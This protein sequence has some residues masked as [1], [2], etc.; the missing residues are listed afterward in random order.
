MHAV[1]RSDPDQQHIARVL[2]GNG[3]S[4]QYRCARLLAEM[5]GF[6]MPNG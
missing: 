3:E 6:D 1:L 2:D 4:E 5:V